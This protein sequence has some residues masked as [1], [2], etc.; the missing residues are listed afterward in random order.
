MY[1]SGN[2]GE[3]S[4][5]LHMSLSH[6]ELDAELALYK[7][8]P[9]WKLTLWWDDLHANSF[10]YIVAKVEDAFD[11][12]NMTELRIIAWVPPM[13]S[14][15]EFQRWLFWRLRECEIHECMEWF[16]LRKDAK[17]VYD[18]HAE[19]DPPRE[20]VDQRWAQYESDFK[21]GTR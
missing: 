5:D 20:L 14:S 3:L 6:E 16:Q 2:C 1:S 17:P 9:G 12:G 19:L 10:L 8:K 4:Y 11:I 21:D 13:E 18:P 7:Y 15:Q